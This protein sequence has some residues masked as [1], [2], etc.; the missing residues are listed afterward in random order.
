MEYFSFISSC[1]NLYQRTFRFDSEKSMLS[2]GELLTDLSEKPRQTSIG[3]QSSDVLS[4]C[5]SKVLNETIL[6][7]NRGG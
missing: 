1:K 7:E 3:R 2:S 6:I 5:R 4:T